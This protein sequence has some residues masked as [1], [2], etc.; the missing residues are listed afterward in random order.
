MGWIIGDR[1]N[2]ITQI[3]DSSDDSKSGLYVAS[4]LKANNTTVA[5]KI[6]ELDPNLKY[7]I[8]HELFKREYIA[9][10]RLNN[11]N[12]IRY[13]DSG[14]DN[15]HL[16]LVMEYFNYNTL[17]EYL[18]NNEISLEEKLI[19]AINIA[20]A[21][22]YAHEKGVIHRDLKPTNILVNNC[23]DI[24]VIDFGIS[25]IV[26]KKY[27]GDKTVKCFMSIK[28]AAPEQLMR[29]EVKHQSDIYSYGLNL[30]YILSEIEPPDEKDKLALYISTIKCSERLKELIYRL[31]KNEVEK[32]IQSM[33]LV[34]RELEKEIT[35]VRSKVKRLYIKFDPYIQRKLISLGVLDYTSKEHIKKFLNNDLSSSSIYRN[36]KIREFY[37]IG[38]TIKYTCIY[39]DNN[40]GFKIKKVNCIDDQLEWE[41]E[42]DKGVIVKAPWIPIENEND[43]FEESYIND[44]IQE[45]VDSEQSKKTKKIDK[46]LKIT[47]LKNGI[48]I[49]KK[50]L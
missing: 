7:D 3:N 39:L 27:S 5:V 12:I 18:K 38:K 25:K 43:C 48:N 37:L 8:K 19:I 15:E 23:N 6:L 41:K 4:D 28:Y 2:L 22:A 10:S 40:K 42:F 17:K 24:K 36:H 16:Y 47:Y 49:Y 44:L 46:K 34:I 21:L 26:G 50:N 13:I 20:K 32:R 30:A 9:L 33:Y 45:I 29:L 1:Y 14:Q 11:D 35:S 31:T